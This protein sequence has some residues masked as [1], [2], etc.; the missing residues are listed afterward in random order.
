M[1]NDWKRLPEHMLAKV[2][3]GADVLTEASWQQQVTDLADILGW[4]WYH[5]HDSRRSPAGFPDL[6][7]VNVR[8]GRTIFAELKTDR[9]KVSAAQ[10]QW[11]D[12]LDAASQETYVWRPRDWRAVVVTLQARDA[13]DAGIARG[14]VIALQRVGSGALTKEEYAIKGYFA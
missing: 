10:Q 2:R 11:L 1:K 3:A 9:G 14:Q 13:T 6:V 12:D 7:L 5:T 8:R 4:R